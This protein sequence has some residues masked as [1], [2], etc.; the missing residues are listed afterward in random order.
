MLKGYTLLCFVSLAATCVMLWIVFPS[1]LSDLRYLLVN[2]SYCQIG[3]GTVGAPTY[4][5]S[6]GTDNISVMTLHIA[7]NCFVGKTIVL[8]QFE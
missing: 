7:L 8:F 3:L 5:K 1:S 6:G 4:W 2:C